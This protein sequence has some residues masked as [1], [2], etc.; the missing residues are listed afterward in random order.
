MAIM[1]SLFITHGAPSLYFEA[2]AA[3]DF[4][5]GL[6]PALGSVKAI[7]VI[8]AHWIAE[9]FAVSGLRQQTTLHDFYGFPGELYELSYTP[10][11]APDLANRIVDLCATAGLP[12]TV[13][14]RGLDHG[15][16]SP[17][18]LM[19]P[20]ADIPTLQ[21]SLRAEMDPLRHF[22]LGRAL[23]PLRE[24]GVLVLASGS[25]THNLRDVG[26]FSNNAI[27]A[28]VDTFAD[29]VANRLQ[30]ADLDALLEFRDQAPEAARN[31]PTPE[32][33]MP[34]FVAMGAGGTQVERLH[35]STSHGVIRMDAYA[36]G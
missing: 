2:G 5:A 34:L 30:S 3:R 15:A 10:P 9:R 25:M 32:H 33:F 1:P 14:Q 18:L 28:Y 4:L 23:A 26:R 11:G 29:W 6:G 22:E 8:S 24:E 7:V 13:E 12:A 27:P 20:Q 21:V 19:Y 36:F 17:L 31:H 16:W 35:R